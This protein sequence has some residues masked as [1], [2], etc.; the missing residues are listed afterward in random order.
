M[1]MSWDVQ[2]VKISALGS[3][4]DVEGSKGHVSYSLCRKVVAEG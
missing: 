3:N 2:R 4:S 1:M